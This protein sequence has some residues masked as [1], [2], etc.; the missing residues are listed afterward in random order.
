[1]D[2]AFTKYNGI[3][4]Y[5]HLYNYRRKTDFR[6]TRIQWIQEK[7]KFDTAHTSEF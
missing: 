2:R 3:L 6:S 7:K 5:P 1:M 4:I